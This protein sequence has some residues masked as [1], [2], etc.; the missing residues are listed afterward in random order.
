MYKV[1]RR[2]LLY[3]YNIIATTILLISCWHYFVTVTLNADIENKLFNAYMKANI[4]IVF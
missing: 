2:I 4:T 1:M 3:Y